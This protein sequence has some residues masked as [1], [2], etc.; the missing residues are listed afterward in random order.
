MQHAQRLGLVGRVVVAGQLLQ[1]DPRAVVQGDLA[2]GAFFMLDR[3]VFEERHEAQIGQR[4]FVV[5]HVAV[6]LGG[7]FVV[8]EGHTGRQHVEHRRPLVR[9][10]RLEQ[11][12]QLLLVARE[13]P[14]YERRAQLDGHD[15]RVDGR[16]V[17]D[18]AVLQRRAHIGGRRELALRQAVAAV[19]LD[20]VDHRQIAPHQVHE[21]P[22]ADCAGIAVAADADGRHG[23]VG[24]QRAGGHRRHPAVHGVEP[25]RLAQEI[26]RALART[27][28]AR[29]LQHLL[30]IDAQVEAG[31]DDA[32]RDR[33]VPAA[34]AQRRLAA[35]VLRHVEADAIELLAR[36]RRGACGCRHYSPPTPEACGASAVP[37]AACA[38]ASPSCAS[39]ASLM[40]RASM[41]RPL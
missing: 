9:Q 40:L 29:Q 35:A 20:D 25:V 34:R 28:D 22:D 18:H 11:R 8:V 12:R 6:A 7:P 26:R 19:V 13:R 17:V 24:Q 27:A 23:L 21:L 4:F 14:G 5:L 41:G 1:H 3:D 33:V 39:T 31:L 32:L 16:Q 30:G 10:R 2:C 15:A 37:E 36:R 38:T